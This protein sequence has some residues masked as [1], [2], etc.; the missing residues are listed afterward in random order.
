MK[1]SLI[2][3]AYN[4]ENHILKCL[5]SVLDQDI[6]KDEYEIIVV[7]DGSTDNTNRIVQEFIE[8]SENIILLSQENQRQGAA[9]NNALKIAKGEFIW[10]VDSDDYIESNV[11][12]F[13]YTLAIENNLDL[14]CFKN[15]KVSDNTIVENDLNLKYLSFNSI[16]S[17]QEF[18][19]S[20]NIYCGPC[21]CIYRREFLNEYNLKF[22]EGVFYEDN[23]FMLRIYYYANR[24][25]YVKKVCYFVVLTNESATRQISPVPI[26]DLIKVVCYMLEFS[27]EIESNRKTYTNSLYYVVLTFNT[28]LYRLRVQNEIIHKE[29][30]ERIKYI[31]KP[32]IRA[33]FRSNSVKY[34]LEGL[35]FTFSS[36]L[37][38]LISNVLK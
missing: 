28:A 27:N 9:R 34:F 37:L 26:F 29:F 12:L 24:V 32:L 31:R 20:H 21:F 3:P 18:I 25:Y 5:S 33:M 7:D 1:I 38:L 15:Y 36:K 35:I 8:H 2:I 17:G 14:L 4:A 6:A 13:L 22:K 30:I 11:L 23:E 10:F 16:Y 19:N